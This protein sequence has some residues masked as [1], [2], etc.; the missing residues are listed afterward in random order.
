MLDKIKLSKARILGLALGVFV[1]LGAAGTATAGDWYHDC[2]R[3]I[4][5]E[6]HELDRAIARHG[7]HSRQADHERHELWRLESECRYR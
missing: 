2:Q 3:Q 7:Y 5:H 4:A 6:H 1:L